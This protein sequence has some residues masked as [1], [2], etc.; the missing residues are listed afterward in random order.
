VVELDALA[1]LSI[2]LT[3]EQLLLLYRVQFPVLQQYERA[4]FYDR[5]GKIVFTVNKGLSDVGVSSKQWDEIKNAQAGDKLPPFAHDQ[6]GPFIP[7]STPAIAKPTW[8]KPT[9]TSKPS[10]I[11]LNATSP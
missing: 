6:G 2:G 11:N 9:I 4:T 3:N 7:P 5:R 1:A 8:P 10:S